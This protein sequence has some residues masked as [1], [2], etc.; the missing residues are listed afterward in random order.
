MKNRNLKTSFWKKAA[1]SLPA[2]VRARY[3]GYFEDAERQELALDAVIEA[4]KS[5]ARLF[6]TAQPRTH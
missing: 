1:N 3:L 6:H 5:F 4:F 2:P